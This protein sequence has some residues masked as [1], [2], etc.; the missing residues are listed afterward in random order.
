MKIGTARAELDK[1]FRGVLGEN[2]KPLNKH[3]EPL[4]MLGHPGVGKTSIIF[5]VAELLKF[6]VL[7]EHPCIADPTDYKGL[8]MKVNGA[9]EFVPIGP[10]RI[11]IEAKVPTIVVFDDL[12]HAAPAVQ[13]PIMQLILA[14]RI[15]C[16]NVSEF[17]TFVAAGNRR[18]D[19]AGAHNIIEPLKT[20]FAT[21]IEIEQ[22]LESWVS[23][24]RTAQIN[25]P[26][27]AF[28]RWKP[29]YILDW[30][31]GVGMKNTP[32]ARAVE[33]VDKLLKLGIESRSAL[34]ECITGA[35]GQ[36]FSSNFFPFLEIFETMPDADEILKNPK[37]AVVPTEAGV[38]HALCS[39]LARRATKKLAKN[40]FIYIDRLE[41]EYATVLYRDSIQ[42]CPEIEETKAC[43]EWRTA[44]QDML[45]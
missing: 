35:V 1:F 24:A 28:I 42:H 15:G 21:V 13:A 14:R 12:P 9:A 41:S 38:L 44:N 7:L 34:E 8:P 20:R 11:M 45:V 16:H 27:V 26:L 10:L 29:E 32:S 23:W 31:P 17:V 40:L 19:K 25:P 2:G 18:E 4:L 33:N 5:Q 22:D 30:K 36:E 37:D 43:I 3:G 39:S 6:S